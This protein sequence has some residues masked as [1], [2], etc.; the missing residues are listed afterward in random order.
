M[1][2][3]SDS[4]GK[5]ALR[6]VFT[7]FWTNFRVHEF[8]LYRLLASEFDLVWDEV[9]PELLFFCTYGIDH[10]KY[11]CHKVYYSHENSAA[12]PGTSDYSFCLQGRGKNHQYFSNFIEEEFFQQV[13]S[14]HFSA[15][16]SRI[17]ETPKTKF[18]N[19]I[20]SNSKPRER[21]AFCRRL[22]EY[23]AVDCP[24]AVLNNHPP[25]DTHDYRWGKKLDFLK[26]YKFTIAFE[27]ESVVNYTTEKLIHPLIVGSIPIY[28]GNPQ[29]ADLFNPRSFVNCHDYG[30]FDEVIDRV[31]EIDRDDNVRMGFLSAPPILPQSPLAGLTEPYFQNLI[32]QIVASTT[33]SRSVSQHP[34]YRVA[35]VYYFLKFKLGN[36]IVS[37]WE[38]VQAL[39]SRAIRRTGFGGVSSSANQV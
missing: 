18:C 22:M 37:T 1:N 16:L 10:L 34:L 36:R 7:D 33:T 6:V 19:F 23:K 2:G 24:G 5:P 14:N 17:R 26:P 11:R 21:I 12:N 9:N 4:S 27:N 3:A 13:R 35:C 8:W 30:S 38:R 29:V 39:S 15:A 32:R 28:W 20:Y 31:K 25:F